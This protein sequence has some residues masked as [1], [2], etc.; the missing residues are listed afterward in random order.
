MTQ[1]LNH[2]LL[3]QDLLGTANGIASLDSSGQVPAAQIPPIF[4][5]SGNNLADL[6]SASAALRNLGAIP[7]AAI[8]QFS[9]ATDDVKL[10]NALQSLIATGG[11]IRLLPGVTYSAAAAVASLDFSVNK[12]PIIIDA[13]GAI[14]TSNFAGPIIPLQQSSAPATTRSLFILGGDWTNSHAQGEII[15]MTD[16]SNCR[17]W[18]M[19]VT[20]GG[21]VAAFRQINQKFWCERNHYYEIDDNG[22]QRVWSLECTYRTET[23]TVTSGSNVVQCAGTIAQDA[24]NPIDSTS[25]GIPAGTL[26][27]TVTPGVSFTLVASDGVTPVNATANA[28]SIKI[29]PGA[30]HARTIIRDPLLQGGTSGVCKLDI[31]TNTVTA[32]FYDSEI[33]GV[34][35]NLNAGAVVMALNGSMNGTEIGSL[36][37]ECVA[38][39]TAYYFLLGTM[40]GVYPTFRGKMPSCSSHNMALYSTSPPSSA[41][42]FLPNWFPAGLTATGAV[43]QNKLTSTLAANGSLTFFINRGNAIAI[44]LQANLTSLL[45]SGQPTISD[46]LSG[47]MQPTQFLTIQFT[48]DATGGRTVGFSTNFVL[49]DGFFL[50]TTPSSVTIILFAWDNSVNK[51]RQIATDVQGGAPSKLLRS[52]DGSVAGTE[53]INNSTTPVVDTALQR[54]VEANAVYHFEGEFVFDASATADLLFGFSAPAGSSGEWSAMGMGSGTSAS[55]STV[56]TTRINLT[57]NAA[58]GAIAVGTQQYLWFRGTIVT[59]ATAGTFG[60]RYAQNTA[61]ASN[62][63][64]RAGSYL[65]ME[66]A[67]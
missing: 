27:G 26:V 28:S 31:P 51:W 16:S 62:L 64:P 44:N 7:T 5:S 30:S 39:G 42:T 14:I 29:W 12:K 66:R 4:L 9:G 36:Q 15:R 3:T 17:F 37:C 49:A 18:R 53:V 35:G 45:I 40:A 32:S 50:D 65:K 34:H 61:D 1:P 57:T 2:R 41:L 59:G 11:Y 13:E 52:V 55:P 56:S 23:A 63:T 10:N 58:F 54:R 25:T 6:A 43:I 19:R 67:A 8:E 20:V 47:I 21:T 24:G 22:C 38:G 48:Q 60:V 33:D 46:G